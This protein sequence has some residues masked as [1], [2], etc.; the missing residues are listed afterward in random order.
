[1]PDD[2]RASEPRA[3]RA[4]GPRS[5]GPSDPFARSLFDRPACWPID[6]QAEFMSIRVN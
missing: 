4:H 3:P 6:E 2:L 5:T 1:M